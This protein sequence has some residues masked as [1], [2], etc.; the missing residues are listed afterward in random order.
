MHSQDTVPVEG[1]TPSAA[2]LAQ[3]QVQP[4]AATGAAKRIPNLPRRTTPKFT[5][6][7]QRRASADAFREDCALYHR[8][9]P[10]YPEA[11]LDLIDP[12]WWKEGRIVDVGCGTGKLTELLV[13]RA[14]AGRVLACDP[15]PTMLA[16]LQRHLPVA[17]VQAR[18]EALGLA[19]H[20]VGV[21][22]CAQSWHWV[23]P[24]AGFA[25]CDRVL[26]PE[27]MLLLVWNTIDTSTPWVHRL[28]RIMHS[29]DTLPQDYVPEVR[30]PWVLAREFRHRWCQHV[31]P[32]ELHSLMHTRAY[33]LRANE[34]TRARLTANLDWYLHSLGFETNSRIALPYRTDAFAI[35]RG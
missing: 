4:R 24:T 34:A 7:R 20:S 11:V 26:H 29:G 21:L 27:G 22:T 17:R 15:S 1:E 6:H 35:V 30:R 16:E 32:E 25:E 28:T 10:T 8:I 12:R 23:D 3:P 33:W 5:S 9:R 13:Q 31:T 14:S 2:P 18:A 19:R